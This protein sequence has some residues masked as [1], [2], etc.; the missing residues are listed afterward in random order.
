MRTTILI[1][2]L[3]MGLSACADPAKPGDTKGGA[4]KV[5]KEGKAK[6]K[7]APSQ[8]KLDAD[9]DAKAQADAEAKAKAAD[10]GAEP[11]ADPVDDAPDDATKIGQ[12]AGLAREIAAKPEQADTILEA[13]GMDRTSFEAA[14]VAVAKDQ[15]KTDLYVTALTQHDATAHAG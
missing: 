12:L 2:S 3:A 8:A 5:S 15:W 10:S 7:R 13:A 9:A 14:M 11:E 4:E 1:L 6:A